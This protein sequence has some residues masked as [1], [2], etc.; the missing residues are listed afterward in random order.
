MVMTTTSTKLVNQAKSWIGYKESDG[1]HK[2]IIDVYNAHKPL[3]QGYKVKYTDAWCAT[4]VSACA[5]KCDAEDIIPTECSC[6]RMIELCKKKGIWIENE[7]ITPKKGD[8]IFYDWDDSGSGNNKGV[9]DHVGIVEKVSNG[10]I[11]VIEGNYSNCVMRRTLAVNAK[12]IRGF[13]RPKYKAATTTVSN[14][15]SA[16]AVGDKVKL[17]AGAVYHGG[18]KIPYWLFDKILYV[19]QIDGSRVVISTLKIGAVTGAVEK[20]WL[21][22]V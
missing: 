20:K 15:S 14:S 1:S 7:A 21:K 3:A 22:K 4:F 8:I 11:T 12:Y 16:L 18:G 2:K 19:R 13:A 17:K 10:K 5:I 6:P 9:A